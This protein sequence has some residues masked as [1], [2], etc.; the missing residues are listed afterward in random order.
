MTTSAAHAHG[1]ELGPRVGRALFYAF[2]AR[3]FGPTR[4]HKKGSI[5]QVPPYTHGP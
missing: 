4:K 2:V 1:P 3:A 5:C